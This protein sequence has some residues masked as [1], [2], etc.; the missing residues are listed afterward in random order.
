VS[1]DS[2]AWEPSALRLPPRTRRNRSPEQ[3]ARTSFVGKGSA[4]AWASTSSPSYMVTSP[5]AS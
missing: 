3:L 1:T 5:L 2:V 4:W